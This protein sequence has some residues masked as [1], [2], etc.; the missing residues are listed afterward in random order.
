MPSDAQERT[1]HSSAVSL[2]RAH[3]SCRCSAPERSSRGGCGATSSRRRNRRPR[4]S[5]LRRLRRLHRRPC[6]S[7]LSRRSPS[8]MR[9]RPQR[10]TGP[11]S[12]TTSPTTTTQRTRGTAIPARTS[13]C[14]ALGTRR[15]LVPAIRS[16]RTGRRS[17]LLHRSRMLRHCGSTTSTVGHR[18]ARVTSADCDA[19]RDTTG[20]R[21]CERRLG[22]R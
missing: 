6:R 15:C 4:Q 8:Q 14:Q 20:R 22:G 9:R 10:L 11:A 16:T 12:V 2:H 3:R 21:L 1:L 17:R 13:S 18:G 5:L 19:R 7:Q